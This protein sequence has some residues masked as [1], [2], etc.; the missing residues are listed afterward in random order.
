M[1]IMKRA[2]QKSKTSVPT[3]ERRKINMLKKMGVSNPQTRNMSRNVMLTQIEHFDKG[4]LKPLEPEQRY[5]MS[6]HV[7]VKNFVNNARGMGQQALRNNL[8]VVR[9]VFRNNNQRSSFHQT[10]QQRLSS[11]GSYDSLSENQQHNYNAYQQLSTWSHQDNAMMGFGGLK[12]KRSHPIVYVQGHGSPG[13]KKIS[14]DGPELGVTSGTVGRMLNDMSLPSVSEVRAN[15]CFSGTKTNLSNLP[16]V[17]QKFQKQSI[18]Q[19][20][21]PWLDTFAGS[22]EKHLNKTESNRHNR[23]RGYMGPT[24]QGFINVTTRSS[25]GKLSTT[26]HTAVKFG[27]NP[28]TQAFKRSQ[29]SRVNASVPGPKT[30]E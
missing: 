7:D 20:A 12:P 6:P 23:V 24:T 30:E 9:P 21:G 25:L 15:S 16:N 3:P 10:V 17:R 13:R 19:H 14:S 4:S 26:S 2:R 5:M 1:D 8:P 11:F 18:D 27:Q 22:L 29:V 28:N